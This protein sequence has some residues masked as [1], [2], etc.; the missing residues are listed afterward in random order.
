[1]FLLIFFAS[2]CCNNSIPLD[3]SVRAPQPL[4]RSGWIRIWNLFF[5]RQGV[6]GRSNL[7]RMDRM[8]D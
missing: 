3:Q 1:M 8:Q 7:D 2:A 6:R 4:I 5:E